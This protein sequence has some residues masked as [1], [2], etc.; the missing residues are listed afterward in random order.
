M[1]SDLKPVV[2]HPAAKQEIKTFPEPVRKEMGGLLFDLQKGKMLVMP[3]SKPMPSIAV[4]AHE[5][6]VRDSD[7]IYRAFYYLKHKAGIIVFHCFQ[8]KSQ[9]TPLREIQKGIKYFKELNL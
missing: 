4:G 7:G 8:K 3:H 9:K 5:L 2:F 1:Q 6:R